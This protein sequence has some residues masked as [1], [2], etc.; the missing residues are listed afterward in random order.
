MRKKF[1]YVFQIHYNIIFLQEKIMKIN[2]SNNSLAFRS[3]YLPYNKVSI[4][5]PLD[6][7]DPY[8]IFRGFK[9]MSPELAREKIDN[10]ELAIMPQDKN[11]LLVAKDKS[12]EEFIVREFKQ[13]KIQHS[14]VEDAPEPVIEEDP[15][16]DF[17]A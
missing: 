15:F 16:T 12:D 13:A 7:I 14:Y 5:K 11:L 2:N 9:K 1:F 4:K 3:I 8:F 10:S 6:V 17:F